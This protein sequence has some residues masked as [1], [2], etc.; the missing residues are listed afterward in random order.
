MPLIHLEN[1]CKA[2]GAKP[3][4]TSIFWKIEPG[5]RIGLVGL[6][7]C[8]KTTLFHLLTGRLF[9]DQGSVHPQRFLKVAYLPQAP[10]LECGA[11]VLKTA[12]Q[13]FQGLLDL[14]D[15]LKTLES[16]IASGNAALLEEYGRLRDRYERE[17]GM[18][19]RPVPRP[20]S[21]GS[22]SGR[23]PRPPGGPLKRR[24]KKPPRF[25]AAPLRRARPPLARRA[26]QPPRPPGDG[27]VGRLPNRLRRCLCCRLSRSVFSGSDRE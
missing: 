21:M 15:R 13:G 14:Q 5:D 4:L 24:S 22:G 19:Q 16:W 10:A 26:H 7:G 6:N 3:V 17:G 8:G 27:V 18:P 1:I 20:S 2:Y 25:G 23:G 9:P 12:L 11:T